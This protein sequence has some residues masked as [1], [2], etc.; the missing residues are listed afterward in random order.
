[1]NRVEIITIPKLLDKYFKRNKIEGNKKEKYLKF[2]DR[3]F[4][5]IRDELIDGK[6]YKPN[7]NWGRIGLIKFKCKRNRRIDWKESMKRGRHVY[8]TNDHTNGNSYRLYWDKS[9]QALKIKFRNSGLY[10]FKNTKKFSLRIHGEILRRNND[11]MISDF[12]VPKT[13]L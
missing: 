6:V 1:M 10:D 7:Y 9:H 8:Y 4:D 2:V 12:D 13:L 11:P 3:Y 5:I